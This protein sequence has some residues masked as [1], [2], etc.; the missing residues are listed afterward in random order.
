MTLVVVYD[1]EAA[2]TI[3]PRRS[4]ETHSQEE[5]DEPITL[6]V[7]LS[8]E[9]CTYREVDIWSPDTDV[10]VLLTDVVSR[11]HRGALKN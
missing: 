10:F 1:K 7:I 6:R 5:A 3:N 9:E 4:I 11:G 8:V 2:K